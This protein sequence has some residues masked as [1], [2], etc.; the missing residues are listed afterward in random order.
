M[1][2]RDS[3]TIA[4]LLDANTRALFENYNATL[5]TPK[6]DDRSTTLAAIIGYSG[7]VLSGS[8]C[9]TTVSSVAQKTF[10]R[11]APGDWL[12][13][14]ANQLLGRLKTDLARRGAEVYLTT[15]LVLKGYRLEVCA[16]EEEG[17]E[18]C[19]F[20]YDSEEGPVRVM[21]Q[22]EFKPG[23]GLCPTQQVEDAMDV[24]EAILF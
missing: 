3:E 5:E 21:F 14:L 16:N 17:I 8:L 7:R 13:E 15:P 6:A 11:E 18:S 23:C 20:D 2:H 24:S 22:Y 19:L 4:T 12:G 9:I 1:P 10:G